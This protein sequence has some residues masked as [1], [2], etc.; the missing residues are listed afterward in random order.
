MKTVALKKQLVDAAAGKIKLD[1]K[2]QSNDSADEEEDDHSDERYPQNS[3]VAVA[4]IP[5][6]S[7]YYHPVYNPLGT[8]PPGK[9][10]LYISKSGA[11]TSSSSQFPSA[12][13]VGGQGGIPLPPPRPMMPPPLF[14]SGLVPGHAMPYQPHMQFPGMHQQS[15][16]APPPPPPPLPSPY[17]PS[18]F[19]ANT[20]QPPPP[21]PPLPLPLPQ[22]AFGS[23]SDP[24]ASASVGK[25]R[26]EQTPAAADPLDPMA[27][28]YV[29]RFGKIA[30]PASVPQ[31][32]LEPPRALPPTVE[33]VEAPIPT[34]ATI[35]PP[36]PAAA[37]EFVQVVTAAAPAWVPPSGFKALS[38]EEI[39]RRRHLVVEDSSI[40]MEA[41]PAPAQGPSAGPNTTAQP[42]VALPGLVAY[43]DDEDEDEEEGDERN[44][45]REELVGPSLPPPSGPALPGPALPSSIDLAEAAYP[46]PLA[47]ISATIE[48]PAAEYER[49]PL[50]SMLRG[51]KI[52]KADKALTAFVPNVVKVKRQA[53]GSSL[54]VAAQKKAPSISSNTAPSATAAAPLPVTATGTNAVDEAYKQF[55]EELGALGAV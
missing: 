55:L 39:M 31:P 30:K 40:L 28:G 22:S 1:Q 8:P 35:S 12:L 7:V 36:A 16:F 2:D 53:P 37:P 19:T 50:S 17:Y 46:S 24:L 4:K 18:H 47:A 48:Y 33:T 51:P 25:R 54:G 14:T 20:S 27:A 13:K 21:P 43:S 15:G 9:P 52:V 6:N 49:L 45:E 3:S 41:S 44:G 38:K 34:P 29:E 42:L 5:E 32:S 26:R 11:S 10:E 23:Q